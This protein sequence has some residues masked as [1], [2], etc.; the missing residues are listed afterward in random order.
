MEGRRDAVTAG[1]AAPHVNRNPMEFDP[2]MSIPHEVAARRPTLSR[3]WV[4]STDV[5]A[6]PD[7]VTPE[8]SRFDLPEKAVQFGTGVFLRAFV[9]YFLDEASRTGHFDGRVVLVGTTVNPRDQLLDAQA[10]LYTLVTRGTEGEEVRVVGSVSRVICSVAQWQEVL[11]CARNP[12]LELVFSNTTEV[13][14]TLDDGD[15]PTLEP[16]RSF[17]GKLTRF[18]LERARHFDFDPGKGLMVVPCELIDDNGRKLR[19]IVTTLARRWEFGD[20]FLRWLDEAVT[21]CNSLVDRIVPGVP[22]R[23]ELEALWDRLGYEDEFLITCERYTLFAIEA[24]RE[25]WDRLA[26]SEVDSGIIVTDDFQPYRERKVRLLN[27]THTITVSLALLAGCA[28]VHDAMQDVRLGAYIRRLMFEEIAPHV[29]APGAEP[30]AHEVL[31]RFANPLIHHSLFDITLQGAMKMRV[32]VVPTILR[33]AES[34]GR[35]PTL[36]TVGFAA[37]LLFMR[38]DLQEARRA[39]GFPVPPDDQGEQI[40]SLWTRVQTGDAAELDWLVE[41]ACRNE[42]IWGTD[43]TR[44]PGFRESVT[45]T[46]IR[47][48]H[49]GVPAVLDSALGAT[50]SPSPAPAAT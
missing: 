12:E 50:A 26:F 19:E 36:H 40:R 42:S 43:L 32:R 5:Q 17:P 31:D 48:T 39:A 2:P 7:L 28:T 25:T 35:A 14:I 10:G 8:P 34:A 45:R 23:E 41:Q 46:L 49:E 16:P 47:M 44:V 38:G 30:F 1:E 9:D 20:A 33:Y 29:K 15:S 24:P 3:E 22:G 6:R 18:L 27:G 21:F 13:G 4:T 11:A 37:Y